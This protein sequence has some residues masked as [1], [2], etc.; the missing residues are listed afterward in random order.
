MTTYQDIQAQESTIE[1]DWSGFTRAELKKLRKELMQDARDS[2][3]WG[4]YTDAKSYEADVEEIDQIL[5]YL[6]QDF[7]AVCRYD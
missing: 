3:R 1:Q 4:S 7:S 6:N 5:E 2:R